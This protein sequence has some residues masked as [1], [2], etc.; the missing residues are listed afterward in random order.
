MIAIVGLLCL[1]TFIFLF[2]G[3]FAFAIKALLK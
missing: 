3:A 1:G 2:V